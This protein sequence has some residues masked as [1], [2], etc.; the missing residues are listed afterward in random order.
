MAYDWYR[1]FIQALLDGEH[2]TWF[3]PLVTFGELLIGIAL[4]MG[5]FTGIAAF[6]GGS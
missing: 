2:Y 6:T 1:S 4:I 3:A 5:A